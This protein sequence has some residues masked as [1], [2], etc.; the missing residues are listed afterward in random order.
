MLKVKNQRLSTW[1]FVFQA[2]TL[3]VQKFFALL[4]NEKR[5]GANKKK[6]I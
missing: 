3:I 1:N 2:D 5:L 4:F 6:Y